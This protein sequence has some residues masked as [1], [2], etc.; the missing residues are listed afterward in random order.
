L[1]RTGRRTYPRYFKLEFGFNRAKYVAQPRV[2]DPAKIK[3]Q[4]QVIDLR[5]KGWSFP[6]IA[7][8]L[9]ISVGTAWNMVKRKS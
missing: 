3:I 7:K 6:A 8:H 5:S 1:L 4:E 9:N 2:V